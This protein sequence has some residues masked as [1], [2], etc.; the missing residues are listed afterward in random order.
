[1]K[2]SPEKT[3]LHALINEEIYPR[4]LETFANPLRI[5]IIKLLSE[6]P[7]TVTKLA[8]ATGAER[9]RVSHALQRLRHCKIVIA[10][11][12]GREVTYSLNEESPFLRQKERGKEGGNLFSLIREHVTTNCHD[13][14][15][16]A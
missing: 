7:R 8:E 5:R 12:K 9:S 4:C 3:K 16:E 10:A 6:Q 2:P 11:K 1:M 13:C 14:L 15:K